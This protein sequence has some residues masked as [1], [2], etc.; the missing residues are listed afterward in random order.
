MDPGLRSAVELKGW[1]NGF[2]NN[3]EEAIK[4]FNEVHRLTGHPLKGLMPLGFAYGMLGRKDEAMECIRKIEQRQAED[5][6]SV[7]DTDL[8]AVWF[9]VGDYDKMFYYLERAIE[10]RTAPIAFFLEYPL[11]RNVT[12]DPRF[13]EIRKKAGL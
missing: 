5:P 13:A 4:F 3:W 2:K 12:Q 1:A 7:V 11:F 6:N 9:S 10:K 8:S